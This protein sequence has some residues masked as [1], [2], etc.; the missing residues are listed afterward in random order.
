MNQLQDILQAMQDPRLRHAA[1]VHFP[2]ALSALG[3]I[4]ASAM[5]LTGLWFHR[6]PSPAC[7]VA[8]TI[9]K[10]AFVAWF[11][12]LAIASYV[13]AQA[14]EGALARTGELT[15]LARQTL[16]K[17]QAMAEWAWVLALVTL[18]PAALMWLKGRR[19]MHE[20][21]LAFCV[22]GSIACAS[23]IGLVGHLGGT[24]VHVHGAG[25]AALRLE[26]VTISSEDA[27]PRA[28]FFRRTVRPILAS[29]CMSCHAGDFAQSGL[30]LSNARG[31]LK[32]GKRGTAVVPGHPEASLLISVIE[33]Q[34]DALR[35]PYKDDKLNQTD[36][37]SIK[38]WVL[39][40]AVWPEPVKP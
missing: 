10:C 33:W 22:L 9:S 31:T 28:E 12:L 13:A 35:M 37:D 2:V 32:G 1:V 21:G 4:V 26:P 6:R 29:K 34:K 5:L 24:A 8:F 11:S 38:T 25:F 30:D 39:D 16:A 7:T 3:P 15:V 18:V 40:G 14:G 19:R 23:W 17:H 20:L 27:D 36:I